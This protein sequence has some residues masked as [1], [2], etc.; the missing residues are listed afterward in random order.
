MVSSLTSSSSSG[1]E[2]RDGVGK[3]VSV[4]ADGSLSFFG[5]PLT[6]RWSLPLAEARS[7]LQSSEETEFIPLSSLSRY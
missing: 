1:E 3:G 7:I 6:L 2:R 4:K 5:L